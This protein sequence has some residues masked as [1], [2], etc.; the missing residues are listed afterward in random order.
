MAACTAI[1]DKHFDGYFTLQFMAAGAVD[2]YYERQLTRMRGRWCWPAFPGPWI[3]FHRS[4]GCA[5][6]DH[7]YV[8]VKGPLVARWVAEGLFPRA[9]QA[10]PSDRAF[11]QDFDRLLELK[12]RPDRW[13]QR[14]AI[15]LLERLLLA[16]ADERAASA[17]GE[18]WLERVLSTIAGGGSYSIERLARDAGMAVSTLRR[19]FR[20]ATGSALHAHA[21]ACRLGRARALL[22]EGDLAIKDIADQ[23]GYADVSFFTKQF[24][25]HAGVSPATYRRSRQ[26]F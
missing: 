9:P 5:A 20:Q 16:L 18:P 23:L 12:A 8:A 21:L 10:A 4:P 7:R 19:R 11:D 25:A 22:G 3:R 26:N 14:R 24:T 13:G 2:L 15:N 1:V 17:G 6:W